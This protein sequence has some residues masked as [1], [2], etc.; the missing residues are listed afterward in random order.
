MTGYDVA[1]CGAADCAVAD[2]AVAECAV[3]GATFLLPSLS[4]NCANKLL[5]QRP[6]TSTSLEVLG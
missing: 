4:G 3:V 1:E 6:L 5:A 2:C